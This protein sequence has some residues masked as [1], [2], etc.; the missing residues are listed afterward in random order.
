VCWLLT[1]AALD[2]HTVTPVVKV[3]LGLSGLSVGEPDAAVAAAL[4][5]GHV[6]DDDAGLVLAGYALVEEDFADAIAA[7]VG[8]GGTV[9]LEVGTG[10]AAALGYWQLT[11]RLAELPETAELVL[12]G[13]PAELSPFPGPGRPFA[14]LVESGLFPVAEPGAPP[15]TGSPVGTIGELA[16]AVRAGTLPPVS[17]ADHQVVVVSARDG[18]EIAQRVGQLVTDSI[19]RALGH[20]PEAIQVVT[21]AQ[22]G[23]A[24]TVALNAA[25][26]SRLRGTGPDRSDWATTVHRAHGRR[27]PAAVAVLPAESIGH[28]DRPLAYTA[29]TR[30]TEHLTVVTDAGPAVRQAVAL[31]LGRPRRTRLAALLTARLADLTGD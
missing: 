23:A 18:N 8:G 13:D 16:A 12:T 3:A 24:G 30:G 1:R 26:A 14:D 31:R 6:V 17:A 4:K 22:R 27:W 21:P 19:P 2:G 10:D 20:P 7:F 28:V 9:R 11:Q 15:P 29:M 5:S 25:I